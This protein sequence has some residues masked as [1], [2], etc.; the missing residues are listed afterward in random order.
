MALLLWDLVLAFVQYLLVGVIAD[1]Q[2]HQDYIFVEWK[3]IRKL[4]PKEEERGRRVE[5]KVQAGQR[6]FQRAWTSELFPC[7]AP[8]MGH[9]CAWMIVRHH[10]FLPSSLSACEDEELWKARA[11]EAWPQLKSREFHLC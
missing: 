4:P 10:A 9:A 6:Y 5:A 11:E 7:Q 3:K 2:N 1:S 8:P